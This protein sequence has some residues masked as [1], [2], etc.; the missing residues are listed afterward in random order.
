MKQGRLISIFLICFWLAAGAFP[1]QASFVLNG[2]PTPA[3]V[4]ARTAGR[5]ALAPAVRPEKQFAPLAQTASAAALAKMP[6][7]APSPI[8]AAAP[9]VIPPLPRHRPDGPGV[10]PVSAARPSLQII[11]DDA[12]A[13][14][15]PPEASG[16][17][18][19]VLVRKA[20]RKMYLLNARGQIVRA[21]D[22]ALGWSPEGRKTQQGDGR[23][24]EGHYTID[25]HNDKSKYYRSLHISY[26]GKGDILNARRKGV[27]PGGDIFIHGK[28]NGKSWM[29]WKYG[30][31]RDWTD[32]CIA[33]TDK[34]ISEIWVLVPDGTP[35]DITA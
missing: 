3:P 10:I 31:G 34:D 32:G 23:T 33:V 35:I 28:P 16:P 21:Y 26:P 11:Q 24:P 5:P 7:A 30:K 14:V 6:P 29:W 17:V 25:L 22:I 20:E 19:H 9:M 4:A 13:A 18:T 2:K 27:S 15:P 8:M 1:V 12:P